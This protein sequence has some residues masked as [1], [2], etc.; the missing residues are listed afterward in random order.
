MSMLAA[1]AACHFTLMLIFRCFR[2]LFSFRYFFRFHATLLMR[3]RLRFSSP[4]MMPFFFAFRRRCRCR[5]RCCRISYATRYA[6]ARALHR[7]YA[8]SSPLL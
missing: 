1:Y 4:P 8:I 2:R 3:F 7:H 6:P 5:Q